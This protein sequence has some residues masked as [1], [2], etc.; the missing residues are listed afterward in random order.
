MA[1]TAEGSVWSRM[2]RVLAVSG[3][4]LLLAIPAASQEASCPSENSEQRR[5]MKRLGPRDVLLPITSIEW[6]TPDRWSFTSRYVHGFYDSRE[7]LPRR[8]NI[9]V[10][11]SPGTAGGRLG[12]GYYGLFELEGKRELI[13]ILESRAVLLRTWGNP[14]ET[15]A[16]RTFAGIELRGGIGPVCN[17][18]V[19]WY[20]QVSS[21]ES[22]G[23][24]I[25]GVHIGI[26]M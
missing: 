3:L 19:A 21:S 6:G 20:R 13:V 14:L 4:L 2:L 17:I 16:D 22:A 9:S 11:L 8:D 23:D 12:V 25:V 7:R 10:V 1:M 15:E 24:S 5:L 18:G 26:G